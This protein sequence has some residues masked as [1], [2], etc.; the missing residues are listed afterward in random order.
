MNTVGYKEVI[1]FLDGEIDM[2]ICV[3]LVK[4]NTR[5]YAKRQLTWFRAE[6]NIHWLNLDVESHLGNIAEKIIIEYRRELNK[7][8]ISEVK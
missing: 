2:E 4:R 7:T 8:D 3:E 6:K 1:D 5:R